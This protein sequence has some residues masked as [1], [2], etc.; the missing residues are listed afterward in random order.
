MDWS[1]SRSALSSE[2]GHHYLLRCGGRRATYRQVIDGWSSDASF[3]RFFIALLAD[4]PYDA[5]RWET[6][7][8]N[9]SL[10]ARPFE[11][12]LLRS[13]ELERP[14][15]RQPFA[16]PFRDA[17]ADC[18]AFPNMSGDATMIVPCPLDA[19]SAYPHLA[20]FVGTAPDDQQHR[21][22]QLTGR[23]LARE[24]GASNRWLNTAGAGVAWLHLRIDARPK[25][26]RH[27]PFR[28]S[29]T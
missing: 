6:P 24:L 19:Q 8:V 2:P 3:R 17:K 13:P 21:F 15:D 22:W 14:A 16:G 23:T 26:Y 7:H 10:L 25:Y 11:F 5:Y 27:H 18:I 9:Q 12:V 4:C 20:A 1:F 29:G 28:S